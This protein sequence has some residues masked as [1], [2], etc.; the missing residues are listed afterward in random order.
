MNRNSCTSII[1][2]LVAVVLLSACQT[3]P[4]K[5]SPTMPSIQKSLENAEASQQSATVEP[6]P[7][8]QRALLPPA[9]STLGVIKAEV[10]T[11]DV[12]VN[13][14]PARQLF[15]SL[16]DGTGDNMV[17]HPDV[18]G[19]LTL[20][21]KNVS[22]EDVMATLRDVYGYEYRYSHGVYQVFPSRMRSQVFKVNYLDIERKGGS[23]TR[24]SS[25]QIT[26][27]SS[28]SG[29]SNSTDNNS[30]SSSGSSG[31]DNN[32]NKNGQNG[33]SGA[34]ITTQSEAN[35]WLDLDTSLKMIVGEENGRKVVINP[36][37]GTVL[38]R[39]MPRELL[40]VKQ[41]LDILQDSV[42]RQVIIEAKILEVELNDAFQTGV[43]WT[44]LLD[45]GGNY[46]AKIAQIGGGTIF[47]DGV[48]E[49]AGTAVPLNNLALTDGASAFG[50]VF[51]VQAHLG[52]FNTLIELLKT[53]GDVQVLSSPRVSTVN[54]QKAIIKVG[55]DEYFVTDI[56]VQTDV[57]VGV[58]NRSADVT[59][60]PFFS[61]VALDVTPQIDSDG[62]ITLH[63]H[64][65]IS[66]VVEDNKDLGVVTSSSDDD[67][68]SRSSRVP[69]AKS[70]IRETDTIV[71]AENGQVV[72]IGGLMQELVRDEVASTPFLGDMPVIGHMFRHTRKTSTKNELVILLRPVVVN[73]NRVWEQQVQQATQRF[74]AIQHP[75]YP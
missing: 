29:G 49:L 63:V 1:K 42:S 28:S 51:A 66:E 75:D 25:G 55:T 11:F 69:L 18:S 35:F 59:L 6:P 9:S 40:D 70:T 43:N 17:V 31:F 12:S 34:Q 16:V 33:F 47:K 54:N 41:Y 50:G 32:A 14:A 45:F 72:V 74:R 22:T 19:T 23:K 68:S 52:D 20:D 71:Q 10:P 5:D 60:T 58:S 65:A 21:L 61:G 48:S 7:E 73:S 8:V 39:A 2:L 3:T 64:P 46:Q 37:S 36:M 27:S 57:A 53:Q 24:V 38:V 44:A 56:D 30:N 62:R 15:M 67:D 4:E 13:E 26:Q